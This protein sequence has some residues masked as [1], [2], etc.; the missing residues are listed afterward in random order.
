MGVPPLTLMIKP[1]SGR[2]NMGCQYCFYRDEMAHRPGAFP[3]KMS[4]DTLEILIRRALRYAEGPVS[5]AFQGGEP[6]LAGA[7]FFEAVSALQKKY[8]GKNLPIHN[9]IQTNGYQLEEDLLQW[10]RRERCLVGVS[11][12]GTRQIHDQLR[13][14]PAGEGTYDRVLDTIRR[15]EQNGVDYNLLCVVTKAVAAQPRQVFAAL[16]GAGHLQF[17]P[18]LDPLEGPNAHSLTPEAL[19]FFLNETF[20]L[21]YARFMA[22]K[23]VSVRAFDNYVRA[24]L[25]QEMEM[26]AMQ[27]VCGVYYLIESDGSVYPCD[28]YALEPWKMGNVRE[29][30]F[31]RL[32]K[33]PV[34]RAFRQR[35]Q[36]LPPKCA[37]CPWRPLCRN[38][39]MR[40]R[41]EN[42]LNRFCSAYSAFFAKNLKNLQKIAQTLSAP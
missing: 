16:E 42:H 32:E 13:P 21:Y 17:I 2:C 19:L 7:E 9:A 39:C 35:S 34:G 41:D 25:G 4:L 18:C 11:L 1:V 22:G 5:F 30:S 38:G 27:G 8:N 20:D 40:D 6:T 23:Y 36:V 31:F 3:P 37:R 14:G 28:F 12:D 33:S 10:M 26:C 15:L 24:L 29:D